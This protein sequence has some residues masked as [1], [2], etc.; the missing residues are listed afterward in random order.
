MNLSRWFQKGYIWAVHLVTIACKAKGCTSGH[1][2]QQTS[3]L[4]KQQISLS[5]WRVASPSIHFFVLF[6]GYTS[7]SPSGEWLDRATAVIS[8][9]TWASPINRTGLRKVL[10]LALIIDLV[11]YILALV[12]FFS[13]V[14]EAQKQKKS[15][16]GYLAP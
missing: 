11:S 12:L 10:H 2:G 16:F 14:G 3:M 6:W 4:A 7:Q 9:R 15:H 13:W 8:L 5:R 1:V